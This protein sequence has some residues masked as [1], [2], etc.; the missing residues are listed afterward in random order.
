[1]A[2][3]PDYV[4]IPGQLSL[5]EA[6]DLANLMPGSQSISFSSALTSG[7]PATIVLTHGELRITDSLNIVGPEEHLLTVAA[8][9]N[10]FTPDVNN[11]DG[12]CVFDIDGA[13]SQQPVSVTIDHLML[14]GGDSPGNGGAISA[15]NVDLTITRSTISGNASVRGGGIYSRGQ[16]KITDST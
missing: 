14:T 2:D 5:R 9:G 1:L 12:S 11:R 7:G 13:F 10:D 6:I 4:F 16:L 8:R 3:E 15:S